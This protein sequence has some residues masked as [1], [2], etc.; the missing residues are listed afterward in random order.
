MH[1]ETTLTPLT[2]DEWTAVVRESPTPDGWRTIVRNAS[3]AW[4]EV[5]SA[6]Y[7][8]CRVI[9]DSEG[10]ATVQT[11]EVFAFDRWGIIRWSS[12]VQGD[13]RPSVV[14]ALIAEALA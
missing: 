4:L 2:L 5:H 1:M 3:S 6:D 8:R 9:L 13:V 7:V 10:E 14:R 11:F 12:K